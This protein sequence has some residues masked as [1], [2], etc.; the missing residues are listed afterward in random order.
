[1]AKETA[2]ER[3]IREEKERAEKAETAGRLRAEAEGRRGGDPL[4]LP[5]PGTPL[6]VGALAGAELSRVSENGY[7]VQIRYGEEKE[8]TMW[9][10]WYDAVPE[11]SCTDSL[12]GTRP[13]YSLRFG[14]RDIEGL[15]GFVYFFGTD[16]SPAYQRGYVW[17]D[18]DREKLLASV[19]AG[20]DIGKFVFRELPYVSAD[21]PAYEIIDGKQR[22]KTL[23]M[24]RE[25]RIAFR[26]R[27]WGSLSVRDRRKFLSVP[28][29]VAVAECSDEDAV[30]IFLAL[31]TGGKVMTENDLAPAE[32]LAAGYAARHG[33]GGKENL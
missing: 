23:C 28:V 21:S 15:T 26:G 16:M 30:G 13:E 27:M 10:P 5:A 12:F 18:A 6:S 7:A 2:K 33:D 24:F 29:S 3:K 1:M 32:A 9:I 31:N 4:P 17:D 11:N 14:S 25:G 8:N 22:L 19:F 20:K